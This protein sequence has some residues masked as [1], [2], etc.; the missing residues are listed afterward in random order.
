MKKLIVSLSAILSLTTLCSLF[1]LP[2]YAE[3]RP[4]T[5]VFEKKIADIDLDSEFSA[6]GLIVMTKPDADEDDIRAQI[7]TEDVYQIFDDENYD[8]YSVKLDDSQNLLEAMDI[9]AGSDEV[10]RIE[11][12]YELEPQSYQVPGGPF[13]AS[14][15]KQ[16]HHEVIHTFEAWNLISALPTHGKTRAAVMDGNANIYHSEIH[17]N[18]NLSLSCKFSDGKKEPLDNTTF[19]SHGG[20]VTGLIAASSVDGTEYFGVASGND[21]DCVEMVFICAGDLGG[22]TLKLAS[23]IAG[24]DYA[25]SNGCRVMNISLGSTKTSGDVELLQTT[26]NTALDRGMVCV[27]AAGNNGDNVKMFPACCE[28]TV[29]VG[30]LSVK[31]KQLV[32][33]YYSS[34][35]KVDISA[36]GSDIWSLDDTT[37]DYSLKSGTSMASPIVAGVISLVLAAEPSLTAKEAAR[38]VIETAYDIGDKKA[39]AGCVDAYAAVRKAIS[40]KNSKYLPAEDNTSTIP[41][42]YVD[43]KPASQA[44]TNSIDSIVGSC[45]VSIGGKFLDRYRECT[46][47]E[48]HDYNA[49]DYYN[50]FFMS[51]KFWVYA[52]GLD[53]QEYVELVYKAILNREATQREIK[54]GLSV[55]TRSDNNRMFLIGYILKAP[56]VWIEFDDRT[57]EVSFGNPYDSKYFW[58]YYPN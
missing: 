43:H 33:G 22:G 7:E 47:F 25:S 18:M 16:W 57:D 1:S 27:I 12:D 8:I 39:G 49:C 53:N 36:P 21:N 46:Y 20:H 38:I 42:F 13:T 30:A 19:E 24:I 2:I 58:N 9:L 50:R 5:P 48:D 14:D 41:T 32:L 35:G 6:D 55:L 15:T 28:N 37:L 10:I 4:L 26:I 31:D 29:T 17:P 54:I 11:P 51:M 34:Y 44:K 45:V 3:S 56:Y 23:I 40:I 52:G